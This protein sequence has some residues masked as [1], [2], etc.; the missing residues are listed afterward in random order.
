MIKILYFED[1]FCQKQVQHVE[2]LRSLASHARY[3]FLLTLFSAGF[4]FNPQT[5]EMTFTKEKTCLMPKR[6]SP[7][8]RTSH[9][10]SVREIWRVPPI[11]EHLRN[12]KP[13]S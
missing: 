11:Q 7:T 8:K 6:G 3:L 5:I 10:L 12:R 2:S 13:Q 1:I 4:S 9:K